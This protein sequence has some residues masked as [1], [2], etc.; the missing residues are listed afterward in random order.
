M[1][2]LDVEDDGK[3]PPA[4]EMTSEGIGLANIRQRLEQLYPNAHS[5]ALGTG[6]A[7]GALTRITIPARAAS[8][9]AEAADHDR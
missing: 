9:D 6:S 1:L 8:S 3:G 4:G 7:G 2:T 5:L